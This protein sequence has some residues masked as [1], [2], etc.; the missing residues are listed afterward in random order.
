[1]HRNLLRRYKDTWADPYFIFTTSLSL[2]LFAGA[3]LFNFWAIHAATERAGSAVTDIILSNI[4]VFEVDGL[5]IYG[6]VAFVLFAVTILLSHPKRIP[7]ALHT[8]TL[9]IVIRSAFTLMTH[10]GSPE[11]HY[12]SDFGVSINRAFFGAD[13]FFSGHVGML[14]LGALAFWHITWIRNI[15]LAGTVYFVAV[16]VLGHIHY[17]IDVASAFFITYGIYR[18]ALRFFLR[19]HTLFLSE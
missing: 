9:F 14:F 13:Q 12:S 2:V 8:L 17:S 19:E 3:M 16:V 5:F 4:P 7:F 18:I 6:T 11:A 1:M 10:L 15:L